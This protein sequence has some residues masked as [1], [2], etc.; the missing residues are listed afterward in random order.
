MF[1][2]FRYDPTLYRARTLSTEVN[3]VLAP[4]HMMVALRE[5]MNYPRT[6]F[7]SQKTVERSIRSVC[8]VAQ[9][10]DANGPD[11]PSDSNEVSQVHAAYV[12]AFLADIR[13]ILR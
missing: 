2:D 6:H 4:G 11:S 12:G 8:V 10:I 7:V 13:D 5:R 9:L 1:R 3:C